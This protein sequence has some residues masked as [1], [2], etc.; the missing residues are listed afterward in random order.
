MVVVALAVVQTGTVAVVLAVVLG[1]S[2]VVVELAAAE[3]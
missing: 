2:V 3:G 1:T